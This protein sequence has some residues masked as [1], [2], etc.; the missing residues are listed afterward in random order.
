MR[1]G[2]AVRATKLLK[3]NLKE[4]FCFENCPTIYPKVCP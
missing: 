4:K 3:C 1:E 2:K